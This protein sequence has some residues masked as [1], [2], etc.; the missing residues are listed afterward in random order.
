MLGAPSASAAAGRKQRGWCLQS[1]LL[2]ERADALLTSKSATF[3]RHSLRAADV[4][5]KGSVLY[6]AVC[7]AYAWASPRALLDPCPGKHRSASRSAQRKRLEQGLFP[8]GRRS[9]W[10]LDRCRPVTAQ[11]VSFLSS[12]AAR[13]SRAFLCPRNRP[14]GDP[15]VGQ[16]HRLNRQQALSKYGLTDESL[17][18]LVEKT[19]RVELA[20]R[21]GPR[22]EAD[23]D[24]FYASDADSVCS[25][26]SEAA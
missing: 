7:G 16:D 3:L 20:R 10:R 1:V 23:P 14:A 17:I 2:A 19:R 22:A 4:H 25:E 5:G 8:S 15:P 26:A 21:R 13:R 12:V 11:V 24:F 18:Q 9:L 6:C